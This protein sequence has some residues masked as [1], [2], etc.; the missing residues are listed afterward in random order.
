MTHHVGVE[1]DDDITSE[2]LDGLLDDAETLDVARPDGPTEMRL[3]VPVD[4][5][6]LDALQSTAADTG[7]D[8]ESAAAAALRAGARAA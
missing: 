2:E 4:R 1:H 5:D 6:T 3:Y 8:V 7:V